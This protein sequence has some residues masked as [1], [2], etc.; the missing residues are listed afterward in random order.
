MGVDYLNVFDKQI[1]Y[2]VKHQEKA[3]P[4]FTGQVGPMIKSLFLHSVLGYS[5]DKISRHNGF[6]LSTDYIHQNTT[7]GRI[8]ADQ[9]VGFIEKYEE[10]V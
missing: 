7:S 2:L 1:E 9:I 6:L 3:G 5:L 8:I 4:E 10:C